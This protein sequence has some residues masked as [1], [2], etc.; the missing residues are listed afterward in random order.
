MKRPTKIS[1]KLLIYKGA[2]P[3]YS[4]LTCKYPGP[5]NL[6]DDKAYVEFHDS[7]GKNIGSI[8]VSDLMETLK[9]PGVY[10][11]LGTSSAVYFKRIK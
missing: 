4:I 8:R 6:P 9:K 7:K 11:H 10:K 3:I 2:K 5:A 1:Q